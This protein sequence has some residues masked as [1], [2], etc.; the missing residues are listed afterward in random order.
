[1]PAILEVKIKRQ[2]ILDLAT[3]YN[4]KNIKVFGSVAKGEDGSNSDIDFL[5][6]CKEDCSLFDLIA[7]KDD[8]QQILHRKIDLV[9]PDSI[10]WT[11]RNSVIGEAQDI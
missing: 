4:V 5:V 3:R 9:T 10:H 8:L 2:Q 7:L 11:I 1:M 6:D